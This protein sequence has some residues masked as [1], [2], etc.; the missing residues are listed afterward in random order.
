[1]RQ[2]GQAVPYAHSILPRQPEPL[3]HAKGPRRVLV[4]GATGNIGTYFAANAPN[5]FDL[6]L[7]IRPGESLEGPNVVEA[8]LTDL[9]ALKKACEGIDTVLHLAGAANAATEWQRL[10]DANIVGTYNLFLAA[11]T[12]G[13]RRVIFASSIHAVSSH[14]LDVQVGPEAPVAPGDLYGVTKCF[15]EALA[16]YMADQEGLSTIVLRIGAFQPHGWVS[17]PEKI[18]VM[19]AWISP[20]DLTQLIVRCIDDETLRFALFNALSGNRFNRLD[21]TNARELVGYEPEDDFGKQNPAMPDFS[22]VHAHSLKD[23]YPSGLR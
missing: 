9:E 3:S 15:G 11:K 1:M 2:G 5:R 14:P 17:N 23:G 13:C 7:M 10:L 21:I 20:R 19:D 18:A 8:D 22:G 12:A 6:R 4:T 16:R